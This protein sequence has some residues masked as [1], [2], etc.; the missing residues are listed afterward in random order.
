MNSAFHCILLLGLSLLLSNCTTSL[1]VSANNPVAPIYENGQA[2]LVSKK[3]NDV[4]VKLVTYEFANSTEL[5][6]GFLVVLNNRGKQVIDF[7]TDNI[8]ATS[9]SKNVRVYSYEKLRKRIQTEATMAA[10]AVALNGASASMAAS[11]PQTTYHSGTVSAYGSG[12]YARGSYTGTTTTY[13][14]AASAAA[15]S[16]IQANTHGQMSSVIH[17]RDAALSDTESMLRRNTVMPGDYAGGVVRLYAQDLQRKKPLCLRVNVQGE[18]HE[19]FFDVG[20]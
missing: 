4:L 8:S 6:P 5:L 3:S 7:S 10:I 15:R 2:V 20:M 9:G 12:G 17:N 1:S 14:P 13:N 16:N 18:T 19:F 11:M